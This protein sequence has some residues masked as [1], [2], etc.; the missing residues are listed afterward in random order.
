[1]RQNKAKDNPIVNHIPK[2]KYLF[3][4]NVIGLDDNKIM[5]IIKV[6]GND[7][8]SI[9][10]SD[11]NGQ[12]NTIKSFFLFLGK[13]LG[14]KLSMYCYTNKEK[15]TLDESYKFENTFIQRFSDKYMER[16]SNNKEFFKAEYY[17]SL[18]YNYDADNQ[19]LDD[20]I[21]KLNGIVSSGMS[22]LSVFSPTVLGGDALKNEPA[23]FLYWLINHEHIKISGMLDA[24]IKDIIA[25]SEWYFGYD[26]GLIRNKRNKKNK[27]F[28][29]FLIRSFKKRAKY[30]ALDFLLNFPSE[31][32][33]TQS[34]QFG[35][36][37]KN[38][39]AVEDQINKQASS[40]GIIGD[41]IN[42]GMKVV[43]QLQNGD[44]L[45]GNYHSVITLYEEDEKILDDKIS[46]LE[47]E[48][49]A[50]GYLLLPCSLELDEA[51]VSNLPDSKFHPLKSIRSTTTLAQHFSLHNT[52]IGKRQGNPLGDGSAVMPLVT[53]SDSPY[54]LNT[55][56]THIDKNNIG[57]MEAGHALLL[58]ATGTGK[59]VLQTVINMYMSRFDTMMFNIDF[60]QSMRLPMMMMGGQYFVLSEGV[61]TGINPFQLDIDS[62]ST[63]NGVVDEKLKAEIEALVVNFCYQ[64]VETAGLNANGVL[65]AGDSKLIQDAVDAV[66]MVPISARR[67]AYV[68]QMIPRS[69]LRE[70]LEQWCGNGRQA[71]ATDSPVNKFN[72]IDMDKIAFDTTVILS[73]KKGKDKDHPACEMILSALFF[74][75]DLMQKNP[76]KIGKPM[77]FTVEEFWKPLSKP[78]TGQQI[79]ESLKAGRLKGERCM[80]ISQSPADA[81]KS[82]YFEALIEQTPTKILLPNPDGNWQDYEKV[83]ITY[84]EFLALK[85]LT[86]PSRC[87]LIKQSISSVFCRL[88]LSGFDDYMPIL[89]SSSAGVQTAERIIR[90]IGSNNPNDW[91]DLLISEL[92]TVNVKSK[93]EELVS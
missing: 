21:K 78:L 13:T 91:I 84:K 81:I 51:F 57:D 93:S 74:Y 7:F 47:G 18:V 9:P 36:L 11:L 12:F 23:E 77:V 4:Q 71:W 16:F 69:P 26:I 66:F 29:S 72:P 3:D 61:H 45:L 85:E 83:G 67:F 31:F 15:I 43:N 49:A 89:S 22:V 88:D 68:I 24:E 38:I 82:D 90:D 50:R 28:K 64:W 14:S 30:G 56:E 65:D 5:A 2:F 1:M 35:T 48:F 80:L 46:K 10:D 62:F 63:V 73:S 60:N 75:K 54:F 58:G 6:N 25:N 39:K 27:Y 32:V 33:F 76:N 41:E 86:K 34:F 44:I 59:T 53:V 17:I 70:R 8:E 55:T 79:F 40:D 20:G 52:S 92:K 87:F 19:S 42:V 37:V